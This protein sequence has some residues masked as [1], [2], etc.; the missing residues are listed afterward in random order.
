MMNYIWAIMLIFGIIFAAGRGELGAFSDGLMVSC[1]DAV[2]FVI[3]LSGIMAVWSGLMNIAKESGLM[4]T[5]AKLTKPLMRFLFP[6]QKN[7]ETITMMLMSFTANIFG[8]G[9]SATVFSIKAM[10][11]LDQENGK[12]PVASNAMCMF[13]AVNMSMLQLVPITII[14]IRSDA[15]SIDPESIIV[16]SIIVGLISMIASIAVCKMIERK[17]KNDFSSQ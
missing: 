14:K 1:T 17:G 2:Y 16:P 15:G 13:M 5:F 7:E 12:S 10:S 11:M 6:K 4:D 9:N 3:G 8:A